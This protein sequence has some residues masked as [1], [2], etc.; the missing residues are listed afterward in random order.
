M[1]SIY[2]FVAKIMCLF[3]GGPAK[4]TAFIPS[5]TSP[6][7]TSPFEQYVTQIPSEFNKSTL[8]LSAS[9]FHNSG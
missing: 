3:P 7:L 8:I 1:Y 5:E 6:L 2:G 4:R 9:I